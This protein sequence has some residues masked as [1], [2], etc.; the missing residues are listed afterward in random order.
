MGAQG[1][2][3]LQRVTGAQR[4]GLLA[5]QF[6]ENPHAPGWRLLRVERLAAR[7]AEVESGYGNRAER[8]VQIGDETGC[9]EG[10]IDHPAQRFQVG[11][12][13]GF[14]LAQEL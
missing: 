10:Q 9:R 14:G 4:A 7:K 13:P 2:Q 12:R 3:G 5:D 6:G 11:R 1:C 8:F